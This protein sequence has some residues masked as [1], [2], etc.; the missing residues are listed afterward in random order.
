MSPAL[1]NFLFEAANF[2]LLAALLGWVL[3]KPV[4]RALDAERERYE[5][6]K[7]ESE[8]LRA[9]AEAQKQEAHLVLQA[10]QHQVDERRQEI[11]AT[12]KKQ[13]A[14]LL[15][16]ARETEHAER[17][18]LRE[19]L[20][21]ARKAETAALAEAVGGLAAEA[22]GRLLES[23]AGPSLDLSLVKAACEQ[24]VALPTEALR[25]AMVESAHPLDEEQRALLQKVLGSEFRE[26]VVAELGA[27]VRVTTPGGQ[28]DATGVSI[29]RRAS[30]AVASLK[31]A[32]TEQKGAEVRH[33]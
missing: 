27:G 32:P 9:E 2:L 1:A 25:S 7:K 16:Q 8:R 28:V 3:F 20:K 10:A 26:R 11:L 17:Q 14:E 22:V 19:E 30:Q 33:G 24:L 4:R 21:A 29:A 6:E 31:S 12:A 23:L 15:E 13:A 5:R 18:A